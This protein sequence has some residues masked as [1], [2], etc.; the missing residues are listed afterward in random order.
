MKASTARK[1]KTGSRRVTE[2]GLGLNKDLIEN[3]AKH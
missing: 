3:G 2:S 1:A